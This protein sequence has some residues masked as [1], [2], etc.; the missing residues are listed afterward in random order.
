MSSTKIKLINLT[1]SMNNLNSVLM[2]FVDLKGIH[3][4]LSSEIVGKVHGLT[5]LVSDNFCHKI[6]EELKDLENTFHFTLPNIEQ[7]D[8]TYD[9]NEMYDFI[10]HFKESLEKASK[11]IK[12]LDENIEKYNNALIQ[13]KNIQSL[14]VPLNDL[15]ACEYVFFRFGRLPND[16]LD[17]LKFFM[18]KPFVFKMFSQDKKKIWCM[19]YTTNEY[20]RE[21]DNIFSS[22]LFERIMIPDFV[23]GTPKD[24][25]DALMN[26]S[27][28]IQKMIDSYQE[29]LERMIH[30]HMAKLSQIKGELLFLER[31]FEAKKYVLGLGNKF[32]MMGFIKESEIDHFKD[33]FHQFTNTEIDVKEAY[34]DGRITPPKRIKENWF[35][36]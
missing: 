21:V 24:A 29:K 19:Y 18:N 30:E 10:N 35:T 31:V 20:K 13:I 15:F 32:S 27:S 5:S 28:N 33:V 6:L 26:E 4:V 23:D 2:T 22:M 17:K 8:S 12:E 16:S 36:I 9:L 11:Q 34:S 3:P 1:S 14:E 7:K 25:I